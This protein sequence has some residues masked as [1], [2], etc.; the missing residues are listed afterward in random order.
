[1]AHIESTTSRSFALTQ[2]PVE[3]KQNENA[4]GDCALVL[5]NR[6]AP[7][8]TGDLVSV[9]RETVPFPEETAAAI[10]LADCGR[11]RWAYVQVPR[12]SRRQ[13]ETAASS[14]AGRQE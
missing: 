14:A 12:S 3:R 2:C 4:H 6:Y 10:H 8:P 5:M 13:A 9:S 1:M 11:S 7:P